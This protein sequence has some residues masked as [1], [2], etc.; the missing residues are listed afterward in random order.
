MSTRA[1][2]TVLLVLAASACALLASVP[3][4]PRRDTGSS[5]APAAGACTSF[6]LKNGDH[7]VFGANMDG[8]T[9]QEGHLVVNP[10][11]VLKTA[12]EPSTSGEY[13]R[14]IS[15]YG[16]VTLNTVGP[17]LPWAGMNEAGL[18]ISSMS[19]TEAEEPAPDERTPLVSPLWVQYQLD[20][21]ATVGEVVASDSQIRPTLEYGHYLVCDRTGECAVI[22]FLGGEMVVHRGAALPVQ[23]L[24]NS[25]YQDSLTALADGN[26]WKVT[27][28]SVADDS[29]AADAGIREGDWIL[30]VDGTELAGAESMET[31][32]SIIAQHQAGDDLSLK[33]VHPGETS[34]ATVVWEMAPLPDDTSRYTL[35]PGVPLQVLSL[36]FL[37]TYPGDFITRF[38]TA[39]QWV[40][41]FKPTGSEEAVTYAFDALKAVSVED[42]VFS[43]AFDPV[44][45]RFYLRSSRNPEVRYVDFAEFRLSCQAPIRVVD[46]QAAGAGD[47][48]GNLIEYSHKAA[49]AHSL[50][51]I[52]NMWQVD[53]SPFTIEILLAGV[54]SYSCL[55]GNP[56]ALASPARYVETHPVRLPPLVT[57]TMM[58]LV[59]RIGPVWLVAGL[60]SLVVAHRQSGAGTTTSWRAELVLGL[61]AVLL[62]P[63]GWLGYRLLTRQPGRRAVDR[64]Q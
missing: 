29:P 24:A 31:F 38:I 16:S 51:A 44:A 54:D 13:A 52:T 46:A 55:E 48:S 35:P 25:S 62:G 9:D 41:A 60:L 58:V 30:A 50:A 23:A 4:L 10:R 6:C 15:R 56:S 49:L 36:G 40:K 19:L 34:P 17:Q 45:L 33:V 61:A 28:F 3:G 37:P 12:W 63:L 5:A 11:H 2:S 20:N 26:Y 1:I 47:I 18:M 39:S 64:G 14:W 22:E 32:Y 8:T 57:W 27:V 21:A 43:V 59:K 53:Y 42:T 7:C